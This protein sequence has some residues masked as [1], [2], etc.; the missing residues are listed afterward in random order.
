MDNAD[1]AFRDAFYSA[2]I[3]ILIEDWSAAR[4]AIDAL[5][6]RGIIDID[7]HFDTH[8]D[9]IDSLAVLHRFVDA[10]D[11][12]L[13]LFESPTKAF[14][15]D[16]AHDLLP[17]TRHC[18]LQLL[19]AMFTNEA[20]CQGERTLTTLTGKEVHIVWRCSLPREVDRY[21]RL[22]FYA[23]DVTEHKKDSER[24]LA[25]RAELAR[26]SRASLVGEFAA[27]ISHE[28][29]QPLSATRT[30]VDTALR[31]LDRPRPDIDEA[32]ASIRAASRWARDASEICHRVRNFLTLAPV[33]PVQL[34]AE[35]AVD[36]AL[37][38]V[39]QDAAVRNVS[40]HKFVDR[41]VGVFADRV[42]VQQVL[43]NLLV[44]GLQ[45]IG[46]DGG[47]TVPSPDPL[48]ALLDVSERASELKSELPCELPCFLTPR[49]GELIIR[50]S[51]GEAND[52]LFEITDTG[53]GIAADAIDALF[54]PFFST[55]PSGMGMGLAITRSIIEAHG[56]AI[57]IAKTSAEGTSF[58]FTLPSSERE[59][60]TIFPP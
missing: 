28:M 16:N 12:V 40:L 56:G 55:K 60:D 53:L 52:T 24:L 2:P 34:D 58:R 20:S 54:R 43:T 3:P 59:E 13:A 38:L 9:E 30:A 17:A 8:P 11:A 6:A 26:S 57:W 23:F 33:Q 1:D 19:R 27:A 10:N 36:A 45:A 46:P 31:W 50:V 44:N 51:K 32:I 49:R 39:R 35:E 7:R 41:D 15:L 42:Q 18:S 4:I 5:R 48:Y 47:M 25:L 14:F 22:H 37:L 29:S 21:Q